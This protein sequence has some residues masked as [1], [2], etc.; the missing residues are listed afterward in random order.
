MNQALKMCKEDKN[1]FKSVVILLVEDDPGDQKLIVKSLA[2]GKILNEVQITNDGEEALEYLQGSKNKDEKNPMPDLIL[3]DL[4]MPG[5]GGK[6]FLRKLKSDNELC[7]IPVVILTTS[8]VDKDILETYKLQAA[9]YIKK[10]VELEQF[11]TIMHNLSEY[12]FVICKRVDPSHE[13]ECQNNNC[14]IGR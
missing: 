5:M 9:G 12:W 6:E 7:S 3:L 11:Q 1:M 2:S 10:P 13:Y 4:N 14:L 8:D